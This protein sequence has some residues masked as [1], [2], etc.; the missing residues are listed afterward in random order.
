MQ[1]APMFDWL[2]V[3]DNKMFWSG[4]QR[5]LSKLF[6]YLRMSNELFDEWVC[7]LS[8][9]ISLLDITFRSNNTSASK[10][11]KPILHIKVPCL[12]Y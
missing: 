3:A 2:N 12:S 1:L 8:E 7:C 6:F 5:F 10:P 4:E 9:H 11:Q